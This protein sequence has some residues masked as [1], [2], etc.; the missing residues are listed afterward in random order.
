MMNQNT[1]HLHNMAEGIDQPEIPATNTDSLSRT[2]GAAAI[3]GIT[4]DFDATDTQIVQL[5]NDRGY[6]RITDL[7]R[8]VYNVPHIEKDEYTRFCARVNALTDLGI[9]EHRGKG[10]F[11]L[12]GYA[13]PDTTSKPARKPS[14]RKRHLDDELERMLRE[15]RN[16]TRREYGHSTIKPKQ[17]GRYRRDNQRRRGTSR[18]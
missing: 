14:N 13:H 17:R 5:L 8:E 15:F 10:I 12:P 18:S 1:L 11:A 6:A 7:V 3:E 4:Q 9:F 16:A 2:M